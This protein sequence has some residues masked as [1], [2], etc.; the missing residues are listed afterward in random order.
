MSGPPFISHNLGVEARGLLADNN[1]E[2]S[3]WM[4]EEA[5]LPKSDSQ[6]SEMDDRSSSTPP[7]IR[8]ENCIISDGNFASHV[9]NPK[10]CMRSLS[11]WRIVE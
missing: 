6:P 10:N 1:W 4:S 5:R 7:P 9:T 2:M 3:G 11:N 8:L